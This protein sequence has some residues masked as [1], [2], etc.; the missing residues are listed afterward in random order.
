MNNDAIRRKAMWLQLNCH[1][2]FHLIL[3][4]TIHWII[5]HTEC[6]FIRK[7]YCVL[8]CSRSLYVGE[9][10]H[11][12]YALPTL[13]DG[14]TK[15]ISSEP[16]V[17]LLDGPHDNLNPNL[18]YLNT[19][20]EHSNQAEKNVIVLGHYE[21]PSVVED[22]QFNSASQLPAPQT[23]AR[24]GHKLLAGDDNK[25]NIAIESNIEEE[26]NY[27][28]VIE[29]TKDQSRLK[30][31]T[32]PRFLKQSPRE[33]FSNV[34]N[35]SQVWLDDQESKILKVLLIILFGL[36]IAMFWYLKYTVRVIQQSQSGS[37]TMIVGG[38][39][40]GV[41]HELIDLGNGLSQVG[42]ISFD[43]ND[44]LGKGCEGTFVFKGTFE[45]RNVA[46]KRLLPEC[47]TLAD[48][49]VALLRESDAHENVV[50]YFCTE[51][52]RQFKYIAVELCAATLQEYTEGKVIADITNSIT[53]KEVLEQA[54]HGLMHLH[55]L[56]IGK[57][58]LYLLKKKKMIAEEHNFITHHY[59]H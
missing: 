5:H 21:V 15:T 47:F 28:N 8:Y 57:S 1:L 33:Y 34:Y 45:K 40:N 23:N 39:R 32:F 53:M 6:D 9:H 49:E 30:T 44:V 52:D 25:K 46:V 13:I 43:A 36:V 50:R 11:G 2:T 24:R 41:Y 37:Q 10:I 16:S 29:T 22:L 48:R 31:D 51:Q 7:Y 27:R 12:L 4:C 55:S 17:K 14:S 20:L 42:K 35:K 38:K 56:N 59:F 54:T 58:F 19:L 3:I 26:K 18:V